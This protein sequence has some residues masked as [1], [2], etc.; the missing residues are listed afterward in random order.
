MTSAMPDIRHLLRD[1]SFNY[2]DPSYSAL[3]LVKPASQLASI[4]SG[5]VYS[6]KV[7]VGGLPPDIDEGHF[8]IQLP[9]SKC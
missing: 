7:F 8:A 9:L 4:D 1:H 2:V 5:E 6:R 3:S